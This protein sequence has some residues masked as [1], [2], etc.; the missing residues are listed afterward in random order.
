MLR[1]VSITR[2]IARACAPVVLV[3]VATAAG[4][5][6]AGNGDLQIHKATTITEPGRYVVT[7][8]ISA[9]GDVLVINAYGV[10]VDLNGHALN[11]MTGSGVLIDLTNAFGPPS[12]IRVQ[13][14]RISGGAQ[15]IRGVMTPEALQVR[16]DE[17]GIIG[18]MF[19]CVNFQGTVPVVGISNSTFTGCGRD[20]IRMLSS[21]QTGVLEVS[22]S[23]I[24]EVQA[25][26][27][28]AS[29]IEG[30]TVRGT[31]IRR[32]GLDGSDAGG[33]LVS[34]PGKAGFSIFDSVMCD[35]SVR[36]EGLTLEIGGTKGPVNVTGCTLGSNGAAGIR[37]RGGS[38]RISGNTIAGN[39]GAGIVLDAAGFATQS[40][41]SDNSIVD[42]TLQGIDVVEGV[43]HV[44]GN[45][46]GRNGADGMKVDGSKVFIDGNVIQGN[47]GWGLSFLN[48]DGHAYR[49]NFMRGNANGGLNDLFGNTDAGGNIN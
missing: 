6:E 46:I 15:G 43:A 47:G 31:T 45:T 10:T 16:I 25:N 4:S 36:G 44:G 34:I 40:M 13:N 37:L 11:S 33:V 26:G 8:D 28:L 48:A 35:G 24:S 32:F 1:K 49:G 14:G 9:V 20:G 17:V 27:I 5:L 18:P 42:N 7:Q 21:D 3:A 23:V 38:A 22:G 41:I 12:D 39:V 19:D 2:G 30:T 29:S